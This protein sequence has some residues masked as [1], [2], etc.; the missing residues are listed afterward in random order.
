MALVNILNVNVLDNPAAF[1]NPFQFQVQF[2]CLEDLTDGEYFAVFC[3]S[4][5]IW[6]ENLAK[7]QLSCTLMLS[8][9]LQ[10]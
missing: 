4:C 9:V 3:F 8:R 1:T 7:C 10:Y 5:C 2:E 6:R